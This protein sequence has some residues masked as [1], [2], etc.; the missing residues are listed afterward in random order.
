MRMIQRLL[1]AGM[2]D[3]F[4]RLI[5]L[6]LTGVFHGTDRAGLLGIIESGVIRPSPCRGIEHPNHGAQIGAVCLWDFQSAQPEE[7]GE[8]FGNCEDLLVNHYTVLLN[9]E[10]DQLGQLQQAP[11][12]INI[13][14]NFGNFIP[15]LETWHVGSINLGA[16]TG[17]WA[18]VEINGNLDCVNLTEHWPDTEELGDRI[19]E[20]RKTDSRGWFWRIQNPRRLE[21]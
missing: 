20:I 2:S 11:A 4:A 17:C 14:E 5:E 10:R 1:D 3:R 18:V 13:S 12:V 9:L 19:R 6:L 15:R 16:I 21:G 8:H 7:V